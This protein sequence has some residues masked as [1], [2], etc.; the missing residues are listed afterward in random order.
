MRI[1]LLAML[2]LGAGGCYQSFV[3]GGDGQ[4]EV[5]APTEAEAD[6]V[7][8]S[9][10]DIDAVPDGD[11]DDAVDAAEADGETCAGG[12]Y[13]STSDLCWQVPPA[14]RLL[15]RNDAIAYCDGLTLEGHD[16]WHLPTIGELRS[17][18][19]GCRPTETG[20][21]CRVTDACLDADC[22]TDECD[23]CPFDG[24]PGWWGAYWPHELGRPGPTYYF[25]YGSASLY[26]GEPSRAWCGCFDY[27]AIWPCDTVNWYSARCVRPGP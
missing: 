9:H 3:N 18:V 15:N 14:G 17:L 16:D 4:D 26:D 24:G 21:A 5:D 19:R 8:E 13:D 11:V 23:G 10:A 22:G 6:A 7:D 2:V 25:V 20:G 12:W 1:A 27:G